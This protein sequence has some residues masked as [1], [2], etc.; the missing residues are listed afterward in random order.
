M[1]WRDPL[2]PPSLVHPLICSCARWRCGGCL[3]CNHLR[4]IRNWISYHVF[5]AFEQPLLPPLSLC[6]NTGRRRR[7]RRRKEGCS[8]RSAKLVLL[9]GLTRLAEK[10]GAAAE[11]TRPQAPLSGSRKRP[12]ASGPSAHR[13]DRSRSFDEEKKVIRNLSQS[14]V[15]CI[16]RT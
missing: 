16:L 6:A 12:I 15:F 13:A 10:P 8:A 7:R 4:K 9:P 5:A 1:R 2:G 11:T 3:R 14:Q